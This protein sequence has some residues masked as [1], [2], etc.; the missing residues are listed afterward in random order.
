[1]RPENLTM[2]LI[3]FKDSGTAT[4]VIQVHHHECEY[5]ANGILMEPKY[6]EE[7]LHVN[8]C[9]RGFEGVVQLV[10]QHRMEPNLVQWLNERIYGGI[11]TTAP[12]VLAGRPFMRR[13]RGLFASGAI[14]QVGKI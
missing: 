10:E 2:V 12:A 14:V 1:M 9:R 8:L 6:L 5:D 4:P 7:S 3:V 13:L 11:L